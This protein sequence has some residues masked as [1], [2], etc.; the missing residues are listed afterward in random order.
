VA[1]PRHDRHSR[2]R[3]PRDGEGVPASGSVWVSHM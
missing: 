2:F 3:Q 1:Q